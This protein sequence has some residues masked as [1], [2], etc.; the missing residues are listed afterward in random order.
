[1]VEQSER[2]PAYNFWARVKS[3]QAT[4]GWSD[5]ELFRQS[6]VTRNTI[7][8]LKTR[9]RVEA[10]TVNAI[11]DALDIPR[12]KAHVLAGLVPSDDEQPDTEAADAREAILRD[13]IYN[14]EQRAAMLQLHD[15]FARTN[16]G[17]S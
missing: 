17:E 12:D 6:G 10:A 9:K 13:P 3:E 11:A 8:G 7:N 4:R 14:D 2:G 1:M 5:S 16:R 15:L